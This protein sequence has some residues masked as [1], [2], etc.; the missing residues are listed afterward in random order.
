MKKRI[1]TLLLTLTILGLAAGCGEKKSEEDKKETTKT[2]QAAEEEFVLTN[3]EGKVVAADVENLAEY[4]T[5]G[6]YK[7]L[8]VE[9]KF[10]KQKITDE[11]VENSIHYNML[12]AVKQ[13]EV[14]QDRPV[15]NEDTVNIDYTGYMDGKEFEGGSAKGENLL[16][17][18]GQFI[19]GFEDGLIGHKKGEE[20][21]L[22]LTFPQDY[23]ATEM[24]GKAVQFKVKI[25]SISE[26]PELTDEWVAENTQYKTVEEYKK[27]QKEL[28]QNSADLDYES[29]INSDLFT[30]VVNDTKFEKYP[31][32]MLETAKKEVREQLDAMYQAQ[33]GITL[34]DYIKQQNISEKEEDKALTDQAQ[35]FLQQNLVV[36]G[37]FNAEGIELTEEDYNKE[38]EKFAKT[39]G[40]PDVKT[41][42]TYYT[43]KNVIKDSVLWNRACEIIRS[44]ATIKEKAVETGDE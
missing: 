25:N 12:R 40:F 14:T 20:V 10:P 36:Q 39:S 27:K 17:G 8:E 6:E 37:I 29:Q 41:L 19:S 5:L 28:M 4:I 24:Q 30:L 2:E 21:T 26:A 16:I 1:V 11:D 23:K 18:S 44:T 3:Q 31:E 35:K 15:K 7:N 42:E 43:D 34:D 38:L 33:Q 22:D 32:D 9:E 13:V